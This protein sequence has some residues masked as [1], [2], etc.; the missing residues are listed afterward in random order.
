MLLGGA[1]EDAALCVQNHC[2]DCVRVSPSGRRVPSF[3]GSSEGALGP[4][5]LLNH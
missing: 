2:R 3:Q 5:W 4:L 1:V